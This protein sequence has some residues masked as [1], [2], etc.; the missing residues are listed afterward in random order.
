MKR[1][2]VWFAPLYDGLLP[3]IVG[4]ARNYARTW[5]LDA[6]DLVQVGGYA[7]WSNCGRY[8]DRP[9]DEQLR[10]GNTVAR[11]TMLHWCDH[12]GRTPTHL[13][14]AGTSPWFAAGTGEAF[15]SPQEEQ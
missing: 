9:L 1:N 3:A 5:G 4:M 12:E 8:K 11:R 14:T 2:D 6:D 13:G 10:I 7:L 15:L